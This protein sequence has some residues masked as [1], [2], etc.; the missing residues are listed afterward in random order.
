MHS[1]HNIFVACLLATPLL[2]Q[3]SLAQNKNEI[4]IED[5]PFALIDVAQETAPGVEFSSVTIDETT[6]S[7]TYHFDAHDY[8]GR[9]V[10]VDVEE[11]GAVE[12]I[13]IEISEKEVPEAVKETL[14]ETAPGFAPQ[15]VEF[16]VRNDG[17][18]FTYEFLG[19]HEGE[20]LDLE[21][22]ENG[23]LVTTSDENSI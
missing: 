21:I 10:G 1:V 5:A 2:F 14:E 8:A 18:D 13:E 7:T 16:I 22:K 20:M 12:K 6:E 15:Y 23:I 4:A 9:H 19:E 17:R 3:A 11:N